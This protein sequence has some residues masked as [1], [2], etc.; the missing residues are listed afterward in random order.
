[1]EC[2]IRDIGERLCLRRSSREWH[3]WHSKTT[4]PTTRTKSAL[5]QSY[6][7]T[8]WPRVWLAA[9]SLG[10]RR[11][12]CSGPPW[13]GGA[14]ASIPGV[15]WAAKG[16]RRECIK[17]CQDILPPGRERGQCISAAARGQCPFLP[18]ASEGITC[19]PGV[20][21]GTCGATCLSNQCTGEII[22]VCC[23]VGGPC[24]CLPIPDPRPSCI[25]VD[26]PCPTAEECLNPPDPEFP[27]E[28]IVEVVIGCPGPLSPV[29]DES[30]ICLEPLLG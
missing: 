11:L 10:A 17:C 15:A 22:C 13:L 12:G 2:Q 1:M 25:N 9:P 28:V 3:R 21:A 7:S 16:G 6:P 29:C 8:S 18:P 26:A 23:P 4:T 27:S 20:V 5:Q 30:P 14:L 24:P 19:G